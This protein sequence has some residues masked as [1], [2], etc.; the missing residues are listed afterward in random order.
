MTQEKAKTFAELF[1]GPFLNLSDNNSLGSIFF[2]GFIDALK[3][4]QNNADKTD[5]KM[6]ITKLTTNQDGSLPNDTKSAPSLNVPSEPLS[7]DAVRDLIKTHTIRNS[8]V[9]API[10]IPGSL[11]YIAGDP[12]GRLPDQA[13]KTL[14]ELASQFSVQSQDRDKATAIAIDSFISQLRDLKKT[15]K[16]EIMSVAITNLEQGNV[17]EYEAFVTLSGL[18]PEFA[19]E[20]SVAKSFSEAVVRSLGRD[21]SKGDI[22]TDLYRGAY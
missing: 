16:F 12:D 13:N 3:V 10:G 4:N 21:P 19:G 6:E 9:H 11:T 15:I 14:K 18:H 1:E 20:L 7:Y 8:T 17:H 2:Q 22:K 5:V